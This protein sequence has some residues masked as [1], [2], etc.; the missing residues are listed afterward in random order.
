MI[1]KDIICLLT[2]IGTAIEAIE[3]ILNDLDE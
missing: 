3:N 2:A 1:L